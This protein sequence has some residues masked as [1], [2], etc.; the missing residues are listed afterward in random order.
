MSANDCRRCAEEEAAGAD[1]LDRIYI[2][3]RMFLCPFC[4]NKRCPKAT[5]HRLD[6]T[7]S[8]DP[9]QPGSAYENMPAPEAT[10]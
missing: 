4:G 9:G 6:C 10:S 1:F 2:L 3:G 8:N 7:R 5:D